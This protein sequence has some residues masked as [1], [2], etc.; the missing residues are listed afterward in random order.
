V[1]FLISEKAELSNRKVDICRKDKK[2]DPPKCLALETHFRFKDTNRLKVNMEKENSI[3][4]VTRRG[5][6]RLC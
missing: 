3:E 2:H 5:L 6:G 1:S 4:R